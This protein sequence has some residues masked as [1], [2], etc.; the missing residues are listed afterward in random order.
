MGC[1]NTTEK[2]NS[3][4]AK[5]NRNKI[6]F[7]SVT[8]LVL[9]GFVFLLLVNFV[10]SMTV[11]YY[12]HPNCGHCQKIEPF[13]NLLVPQYNQVVWN[14]FDTSKGS[15][16]VSTTPTLRIKTNDGREI[17]LKGSQEIPR[18]LGCELDEQS[19]LNC[20]TYSADNCIGASWFIR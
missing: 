4:T 17:E 9:I 18:W 15:Y 13:I 6:I 5:C 8:K 1:N 14:L 10:S 3:V 11:N 7:N 20:P 19:N 2:C 12:Y 16:D